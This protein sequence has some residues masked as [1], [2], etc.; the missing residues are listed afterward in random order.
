M[1]TAGL[2]CSCVLT[3]SCVCVLA[4]AYGY[5]LAACAIPVF[6]MSMVTS[7]IDY[8]IE[9]VFIGCSLASF[10]VCQFWSSIMFSPN[11]VGMSNAI[12]GGWGNAGTHLIHSS[13]SPDDN[14]VKILP[15]HVSLH[16]VPCAF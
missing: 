14:N 2:D 5:L 10:V 8:I 3:K 1:L 6:C 13:G 4:A 16:I 12:A 7:A 15:V 9:R 11:V